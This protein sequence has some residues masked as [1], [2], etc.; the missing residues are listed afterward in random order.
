MCLGVFLGMNGQLKDG[1]YIE[2]N[3]HRNVIGDH[4][5]FK[6]ELI[7]TI[8]DNFK[9]CKE[10]FVWGSDYFSEIIPNRNEGSWVVWDKTGN[11]DRDKGFGSSWELCWSKQ[12]HKRTFARIWWQGIFGVKDDSKNRCH[13]TQKPTQLA[14]W[15]FDRWG[16]DK[17]NIIDLF[18]GSGSTLI[19]CEKTGRKC[20]GMEI[21]PHYCSVIIKR[22]QE[23][24]GG[25]A[26]KIG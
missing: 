17:T 6:P 14:E 22:W 19:A 8:F 13:P 23:F 4:S 24:S 10:I 1:S 7:T 16:K 5:D 21:D 15:F 25:V 2:R 11:E 9:Y 12:K 26:K 3:N 18:L 20:F